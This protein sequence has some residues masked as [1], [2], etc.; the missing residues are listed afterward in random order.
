MVETVYLSSEVSKHRRL[1]RFFDKILLC[2]HKR[3]R[4]FPPVPYTTR[5]INKLQVAIC[6][7]PMSGIDS[8]GTDSESNPTCPVCLRDDV[9]L[10]R[11]NCGH[12]CCISCFE[13]MMAV[14]IP[15]RNDWS[16]T[17]VPSDDELLAIP[18]QG[19]CPMCRALVSLFDLV[20]EEGY[21]FRQKET[22]TDLAGTGLSGLV[23]T[24]PGSDVGDQSLHFPTA[25]DEDPN[26]LDNRPYF[27]IQRTND[28]TESGTENVY[29]EAGSFFHEQ[30]RSFHGTVRWRDT[31]DLNQSGSLE[32]DLSFFFSSDFEHVSRGIIV[33]KRRY[34]Q[35]MIC[36]RVA[37]QFPLDGEWSVQQGEET[38]KDYI[39]H[40]N[41][42]VPYSMRA[43]PSSY[44]QA[45]PLR[46]T[47]EGLPQLS[48][49]PFSPNQLVARSKALAVQ[50]GDSIEWGV[51]SEMDTQP[52]MIWLRKSKVPPNSPLVIEHVGSDHRTKVHYRKYHSGSNQTRLPEYH[53]NTVWGNTF[54]QGLSVGLASYHFLED[55]DAG[56]YISYE[57]QQTSMW[58]TLDNGNP[59]P[60]RIWFVDTSFDEELRIF[61]GKIDWEATHST[62]WQGSRCWRYEMHFDQEYTCIVGG[63]VRSMTIGS[64]TESDMSTFGVQLVYINA[65]FVEHSRENSSS[66]CR[67]RIAEISA[68]IDGLRREGGNKE[69]S[70][71]VLERRL[72]MFQHALRIGISVPS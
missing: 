53:R 26:S 8:T 55:K 49:S 40:N 52:I 46:Y 57:H 18:T 38:P 30:T 22:T 29:L 28:Q 13:H 48:Q 10:A 11:A 5:N 7:V 4:A 25:S 68:D 37:C 59:I 72:Q 47:D 43:Q 65:G 23:F 34:C 44:H 24:L 36:S 62:T 60:G 50:I 61:R 6:R 15:H 35:P 70:I 64:E 17:L 31:C 39:V 14:P 33:H 42:L 12:S 20:L 63:H 58:P 1:I 9:A 56:V 51:T 16:P 67:R 3:F 2:W 21:T 71:L 69:E 27:Q 54:C 32:W 41:T 19:R 66:E 45:I